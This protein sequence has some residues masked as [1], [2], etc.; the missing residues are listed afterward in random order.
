[1]R[2]SLRQSL[3]VSALLVATITLPVRGQEVILFR[4]RSSDCQPRPSDCSQPGL[5]ST[6]PGSTAA[7]AAPA[8]PSQTD[9]ALAPTASRSLGGG[10]MAMDPGAYIDSAVP[11]TLF[12]LRFDAAYENNVPDR[13]E[14][15]YAKCGCFRF[16]SPRNP[17]FDPK[18]AGPGGPGQQNVHV[19]YQDI[20]GYLEV[21]PSNRW[22]AF[23]E[24]PVRF[25]N[26][27]VTK[28][29]DGIAD[30]NFGGKFALIADECQY[31]TFQMRVYVPTGDA[32]EG[33]GN[34]HVSLEP[35]VLFD[36]K[37]SDDLVL[38]GEFRDWI[39]VG[40]SDFAGNIIRYGIGVGYT[41]YQSC[42]LR[43]TPVAEL[44]GWTVLDG[45]EAR[46]DGVHD[47][48]G[49]TIINAKLGVRIGLGDRSDLAISYGRALTGDVWYKDIA[50][51]E[52][53]LA[54]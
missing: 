27:D 37:L 33:L 18:A 16:V 14:F 35:A 54:F 15:F 51:F 8:V 11:R 22:S 47:A 43:V 5:P 34:D 17:E 42:H 52:Y 36:R 45:K 48:G 23:V 41:V 32:R 9:V 7:P 38:F 31:V 30:M 4:P 53:R 19:D 3:A 28:N 6:M 25:L 24:L 2:V 1:M 40:G 20:S 21:A 49:D 39:P 26:P 44:V 29:E 13:A 46:A 10:D 12:R 50:R